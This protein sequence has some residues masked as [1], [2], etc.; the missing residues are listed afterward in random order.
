MKVYIGIECSESDSIYSQPYR[1]VSKV[2]STQEAAIRWMQEDLDY[3]E[4]W[5]EIEERDLEG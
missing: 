5:R 1:Y 4:D 2:F 3:P